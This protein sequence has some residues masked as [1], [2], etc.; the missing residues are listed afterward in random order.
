MQEPPKVVPVPVLVPVPDV[1]RVNSQPECESV[2]LFEITTRALAEDIS[3]L[4]DTH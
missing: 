2:N 3:V 1:L 4:T